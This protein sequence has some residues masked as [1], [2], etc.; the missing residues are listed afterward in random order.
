MKLLRALAL[1]RTTGIVEILLDLRGLDWMIPDFSSLSRRKK[2][3]KVNIP[4]CGSHG[5]LHLPV[6]R[7]WVKVEDEGARDARKRRL[8]QK[9]HLGTVKKTLDIRA[10]DFICA[11][12]GDAP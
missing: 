2:P 7:R 8:R 5:L 4:Y 12:I 1:R 11:E 6:E 3:L 9:G 10:G